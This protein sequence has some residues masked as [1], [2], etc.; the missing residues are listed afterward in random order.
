MFQ[1]INGVQIREHIETKDLPNLIDKRF[2]IEYLD[3]VYV[4]KLVCLDFININV[5]GTG[6]MPLRRRKYGRQWMFVVKETEFS[7]R[8]K[9]YAEVCCIIYEKI[10]DYLRTEYRYIPGR[11]ILD[12][13]ERVYI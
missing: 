10:G 2:E 3:N 7:I 11:V 1:N 6:R 4:H 13:I 5:I 8:R 12:S 9:E